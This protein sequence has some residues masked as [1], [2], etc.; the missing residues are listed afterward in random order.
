[1]KCFS[2]APTTAT[3]AGMSI[4]VVGDVRSALEG[5]PIAFYLEPLHG[6]HIVHIVLLRL[7]KGSSGTTTPPKQTLRAPPTL[8]W[9]CF[10]HASSGAIWTVAGRPPSAL[11]KILILGD[12]GVGKTALARALCG[13]GGL[14][15]EYTPGT[16]VAVSARSF[17]REDYPPAVLEVKIPQS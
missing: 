13:K 2:P 1:M 12:N 11:F 4:L 5:V 7:P 10:G 17:S 6:C 8:H 16:A 9:P 3:E 15:P 14:L